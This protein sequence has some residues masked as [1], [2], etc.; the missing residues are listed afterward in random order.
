MVKDLLTEAVTYTRTI[1]AGYQVFVRNRGVPVRQE[2]CALVVLG[3]VSIDRINSG[4]CCGAH[5]TDTS[6]QLKVVVECD[7]GNL[8]CTP[9]ARTSR[10]ENR[11][12]GGRWHVV[13]EYLAVRSAEGGWHDAIYVAMELRL[14]DDTSEDEI[15][16]AFPETAVDPRAYLSGS[17][18]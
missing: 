13:R 6:R 4:C 3:G 1:P 2:P 15:V 5:E 8:C 7:A 12:G 10:I 18:P 17:L 16:L 11:I 9:R 14:W